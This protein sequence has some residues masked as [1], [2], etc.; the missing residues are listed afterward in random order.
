MDELAG[1]VALITG[2]GR[3]IG[4]LAAIRL[5]GRGVRVALVSRS[6]G[7]LAS[8]AMR[9]PRKAVW[10]SLFRL[11]WRRPSLSPT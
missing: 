8:T 6:A 3:G 4:R 2:A 9:S 10:R 1:R 5:S 11:T 7:Q